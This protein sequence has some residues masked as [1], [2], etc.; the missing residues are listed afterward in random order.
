M[1]VAVVAA[2]PLALEETA[3]RMAAAV[4]V[5]VAGAQEPE[6][7]AVHTAVAEEG[8]PR[9]RAAH[10]VG[11]AADTAAPGMERMEPCFRR[12]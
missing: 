12:Q 10:T 6:E 11:T 1:P 5:A 4:A 8:I 3:A 2:E 7:L 9:V